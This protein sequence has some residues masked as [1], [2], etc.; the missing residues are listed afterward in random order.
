LGGIIIGFL[1][2]IVI[3]AGTL[4]KNSI[5]NVLTPEERQFAFDYVIGE[6]FKIN[7]NKLPYIGTIMITLLYPI[8][9][10]MILLYLPYF[11]RSGNWRKHS[12]FAA[13]QAQQWKC[14]ARRGWRSV[15]TTQSYSPA[16]H[17]S[18]EGH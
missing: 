16:D 18:A 5:P 11:S 15:W 10:T 8:K 7:R 12:H 13:G 9:Y 6:W 14:P 1:S 4:L 2:V 17:L 3:L